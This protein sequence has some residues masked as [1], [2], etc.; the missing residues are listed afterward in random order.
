MGRRRAAAAAA[1]FLTLGLLAACENDDGE[2][3]P[4]AE[5]T[6]STT[7]AEVTSTTQTCGPGGQ[8]MTLDGVRVRQF[9]GPALAEATVGEELLVFPGGECARGEDW[10]SLNI[11]FEVVDPDDLEAVADPEFRSFTVLMGRHALAGADAAP[12]TGDGVSTEAVITF[13]VPD[14]SF[15]ASDTTVTLV[16]NRF[17][18][19][20]SGNGF[21][22]Q[23]PEE[24]FPVV[25]AFTCD[26]NVMP[27]EQVRT[28]VAS[29]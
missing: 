16:G 17:A 27:L 24:R 1:L 15:L 2:P 8:S 13:A 10:F 3:T 29:R 12:V 4:A 25:G 23:A 20:F 26:A 18:G 9:C 28:L 7:P 21:L 6:T 19:T 14:R 5:E 11:G 22:A